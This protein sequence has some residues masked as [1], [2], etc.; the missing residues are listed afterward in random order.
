MQ[1]RRPGRDLDGGQ[2][3]LVGLGCGQRGQVSVGVGSSGVLNKM[4]ALV[5]KMSRSGATISLLV[6][7]V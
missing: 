5:E 4:L 3:V 1:V 2:A 7:L 6:G